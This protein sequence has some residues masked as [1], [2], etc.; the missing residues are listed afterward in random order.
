[1]KYMD[2]TKAF[3]KDIKAELTRVSWPSKEN[4]IHSTKVVILLSILLAMY[5]G[6]LDVFFQYIMHNILK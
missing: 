4:V 6:G 2:K 1:M 5:I 3:F